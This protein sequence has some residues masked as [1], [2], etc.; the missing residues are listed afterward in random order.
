ML[1]F[2]P[3][4]KLM[5]DTIAHNKYVSKLYK[6][7]IQILCDKNSLSAFKRCIKKRDLTNL[8]SDGGCINCQLCDN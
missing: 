7:F 2:Y 5:E 4:F 8:I 1:G 3:G 6:N